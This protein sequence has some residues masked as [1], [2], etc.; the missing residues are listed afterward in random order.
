[1]VL[2]L[3]TPYSRGC[4]RNQ[5]HASALGASPP[6]ATEERD[7]M[8][9]HQLLPLH[10]LDLRGHAET[11]L[12]RIIDAQSLWDGSSDGRKT[13]Q[14]GEIVSCL[15]A[16]LDANTNLRE[17]CCDARMEAI[18]LSKP[19]RGK[20][21]ASSPAPL[22]APIVSGRKMTRTEGNGAAFLP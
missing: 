4:H 22:A 18:N 17:T 16:V 14:M 13:G 3:F 21:S 8:P 11:Q 20:R 2:V 6:D 1:M 19:P 15:N 12:R 10:L 5:A 7:F 9:T